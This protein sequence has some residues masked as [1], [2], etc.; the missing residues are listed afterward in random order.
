MRWALRFE[1]LAAIFYLN[2]CSTRTPAPISQTRLPT[3][4]NIRSEQPGDYYVGRRYFKADYKFWGYVRRPGQPWKTAHLVM[5]NEKLK[6]A[7]DR[8]RLNF[9]FDNNYEYKLYGS[10][11]GRK[12]YEP[13]SD[14]IYPEFVLKQCELIS[15][16]PPAIFR[17]QHDSRAAAALTRAMIEKPE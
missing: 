11:S 14:G 10:F 15:A 5:L 17:S 4:E 13:K 7:P 3:A 1:V 6:L 8:E 16:S 12:V 9:G 2:G